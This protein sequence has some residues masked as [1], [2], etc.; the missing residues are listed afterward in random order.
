VIG[1]V[2]ASDVDAVNSF[3]GSEQM[4]HV[5][6]QANEMSTTLIEIVWLEN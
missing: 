6:A 3:L 2:G 5:L 4:Q 1:E